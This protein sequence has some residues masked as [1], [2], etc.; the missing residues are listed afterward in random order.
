[1][2]VVK[3]WMAKGWMAGAMAAAAMLAAGS[4]L[5]APAFADVSRTWRVG[6]LTD[7]SVMLVEAGSLQQ[8]AGN[9]RAHVLVMLRKPDND[10][11]YYNVT[12]EADCAGGRMRA[13]ETQYL[14]GGLNVLEAER[15]PGPWYGGDPTSNAGLMGTAVCDLAAG[16]SVETVSGD[17]ASVRAQYEKQA[18]AQGW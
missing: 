15:E 1:M 14:D 6:A 3:G 13:F 2:G 8:A 5:A 4:A 9:V 10:V 17:L 11:F 12:V 7:T 18:A 16:K